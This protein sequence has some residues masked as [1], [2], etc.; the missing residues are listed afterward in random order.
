[1]PTI[2]YGYGYRTLLQ[3][4]K[5]TILGSHVVTLLQT[6]DVLSP[7]YPYQYAVF[8][9]HNVDFIDNFPPQNRDWTCMG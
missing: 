6:Y 2:A 7:C 3:K 4:Y 5:G 8:I 9:K 1:M